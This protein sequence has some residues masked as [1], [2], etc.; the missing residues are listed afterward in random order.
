MHFSCRHDK[1]NEFILFTAIIYDCLFKSWCGSIYYGIIFWPPPHPI[2][3]EKG[4][5]WLKM[6]FCF[7]L[8]FHG[9]WIYFT[10]F[11]AM[12][13]DCQVRIRGGS[14][15]YGI[16]FWPPPPRPPNPPSKI[17][18]DELFSEHYFN[19]VL[20]NESIF[21]VLYHSLRKIAWRVKILQ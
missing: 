11:L 7:I 4:R 20:I 14:I 2:K 17:K 10:L 5:H 9:N 21:H 15:Y 6:F 1:M 18:V 3:I 12:S 13:Y 8:G 16:I 19:A